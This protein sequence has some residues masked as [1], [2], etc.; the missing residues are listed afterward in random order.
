L[1]RYGNNYDTNQCSRIV[2]FGYWIGQ[3]ATGII[4]I[5]CFILLKKTDCIAITALSIFIGLIGFY[6]HCRT[7]IRK[8]NTYGNFVAE[9]IS[10]TFDS[11]NYRSG[12]KCIVEFFYACNALLKAAHL[13]L[14]FTYG[15]LLLDLLAAYKYTNPYVTVVAAESLD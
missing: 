8:R 1:V 13:I 6:T 10:L 3:I 4:S 14:N 15:I 12:A 5:V 7:G 2:V 11:P 9:G